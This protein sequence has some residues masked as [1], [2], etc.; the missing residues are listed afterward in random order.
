M[1]K[2]NNYFR[3]EEVAKKTGLTQRTLRYYE[4]IQLIFPYRAESGYRF[5]T[6][7]DLEKI[8]R[9]KEIKDC[10][11]FSLHENKGHA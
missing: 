1:D 2:N 11:G 4:D 9:I 10:L 8:Q 6:L 5:Y 7:E 3:I